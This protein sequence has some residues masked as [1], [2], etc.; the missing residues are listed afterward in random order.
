MWKFPGQGPL[1]QQQ[2]SCCIDKAGSL[3]QSATRELLAADIILINEK[4]YPFCLLRHWLEV[5]NVSSL[6]Q[7][8]YACGPGILIWPAIIVKL[9]KL[10]VLVLYCCITYYPNL[11]ASTIPIYH[12]MVS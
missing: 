5:R 11:A 4:Y 7:N 10:P 9:I 2:Q 3:T 8:L 1:L 6:V 12:F